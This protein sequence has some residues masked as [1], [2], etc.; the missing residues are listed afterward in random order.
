MSGAVS[1]LKDLG[2]LGTSSWPRSSELRSGSGG[3]QVET[4]SVRPGFDIVL[5]QFSGAN[6]CLFHHAEPED[7]F[8][9]GFHLLGGARFE[10]GRGR[11]ETCPLEVWAAAAPRGGCSNFSLP[12]QGFR[13]VSLRFELPV[14]T[15]LLARHGADAEPIG[16]LVRH[17]RERTAFARLS[18][19]DHE[20]AALV[21]TMFGN[22]YASSARNLFLESCALGLLAAQVHARSRGADPIVVP[23]HRDR[24]HAARRH[25][26][27][28]LVDPPTIVALA[29]LVGTNEFTLKRAFKQIF[30]Q[31]VFAYVRQRRMERAAVDLHA[32]LPVRDAALAVG[33]ECPRCFADAFRRHFGVLP[34]Q[35]TRG[36]LDIIPAR[37]G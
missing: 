7:V 16:D 20:A 14:A 3:P 10:L 34:S 6:E 2:V 12:A 1:E 21:E 31:T 25:L 19:L 15:D 29:R 9:I 28:H 32:G 13:T 4:I 18:P 37:P 36:V 24:M 33:Y 35:V 11:F 26:D 8:G 5:S 23:L 22:R 27:A 17:A 30:G